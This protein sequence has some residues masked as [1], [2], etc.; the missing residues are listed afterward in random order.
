MFTEGPRAGKLS[1]QS[2]QT[3][4]GLGRPTGDSTE[5]SWQPAV[6][7]VFMSEFS[8][9]TEHVWVCME[10]YLKEL[11]HVTVE[12]DRSG[13]RGAGWQFGNSG[14]SMLQS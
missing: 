14:R 6:I 5:L 1:M 9:E 4:G 3:L 7:G 11:A 2:H 13:V 10:T 8:R 12:A